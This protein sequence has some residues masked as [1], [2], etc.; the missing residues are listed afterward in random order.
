MI[1]CGVKR[2]GELCYWEIHD[3]KEQFFAEAKAGLRKTQIKQQW[4]YQQIQGKPKTTPVVISFFQNVKDIFQKVVQ[5]N[6]R[7]QGSMEGL[8]YKT[9]VMD[10][11]FQWLIQ[12]C[13][14]KTTYRGFSIFQL[15][16]KWRNFPWKQRSDQMEKNMLSKLTKL[17]T[18]RNRSKETEWEKKSKFVFSKTKILQKTAL[19][20]FWTITETIWSFFH[21]WKSKINAIITVGGFHPSM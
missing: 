11:R 5:I 8:D 18:D 1:P 15:P 16:P 21:H 10:F 4:R 2:G 9:T 3:E 17:P 13:H 7:K 20:L 19:E 14:L 6:G 12:C